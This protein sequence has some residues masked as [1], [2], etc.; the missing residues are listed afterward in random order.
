MIKR[1]PLPNPPFVG[2]CLCR[3]VRWRFDARPLALNACHCRDCKKLTGSTHAE[4][5]IGERAAFHHEQGEVA[6]FRKRADSG[7]EIDVVRCATCGTRSW[8]EPLAAPKLIFIMAGGLDDPSWFLPTGHI[9][10]EQA[11]PGYL[12]AED[13]VRIEGQP[14]DR[15]VLLDAFAR[16]YPDA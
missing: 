3:A 5:L 13:A 16:I 14:G 10:A 1:P 6:R 2:G 4:V 15:Q 9:W 11:A 12:F 8:H 7:R